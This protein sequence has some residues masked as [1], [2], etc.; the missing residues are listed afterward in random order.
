MVDRRR[1]ALQRVRSR[2]R[3]RALRFVVSLERGLRAWEARPARVRRRV[4]VAV[5]LGVAAALGGLAVSC[6]PRVAEPP[7]RAIYTPASLTAL[8]GWTTDRVD[9]IRPALAQTCERLATQPPSRT[10]ATRG[11]ATLHTLAGTVADWQAACRRLATVP[12]GDAEAFRAAI[13]R[14]FRAYAITSSDASARGLFTGYYEAHIHAARARDGRYRIPVYGPPDD[15]IMANGQ[16]TQAGGGPYHTRAAIED[17]ALSGKAPVLFW[18]DDPVDLHILHIQGSG[19]VTLPD[20]SRTRIGYAANNGQPF[21]GIGKL[22]RERGLTDGRSM[23]A[24][25]AWLRANPEQGQALMRENPRYIFFREI[26]GAGPIG[27]L[28]VP[29]TPLRSLAVDP[30]IIPLGALVWLDTTDPDGRPLRRLMA[31]QDTGSAIK[32]I[33]R[34]DVFWG[35]GETAFHQAGRMANPG[36]TWLLVPRTADLDPLMM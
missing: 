25:R 16:G 29:L 13:Q 15:L 21:V 18:A 8:P 11:P 28:G 23:P 32:G 24:I 10:L 20:G 2:L 9:E 3:R 34:G 22:V 31:A 35:A 7:P 30:T 14:Q 27:A 19:Q 33:N 17:G 12:E 6:A 26:T 1:A 4:T 36:R 5:G